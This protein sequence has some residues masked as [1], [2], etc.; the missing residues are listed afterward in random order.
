MASSLDPYQTFLKYVGEDNLED[1]FVTRIKDWRWESS[2]F[3]HTHL[4]L[5]GRPS[6]KAAVA[7]PDLNNAL[8][9]VLGYETEENL[10]RHYDAIHNGELFAGRLQLLLPFDSR[11]EAGSAG[12]AHCFDLV[13]RAA[14]PQG[15]RRRAMVSNQTAGS[16][17][18]HRPAPS[19]TWT[20]SE[21]KI[22]FGT[23]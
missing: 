19:G 18:L 12:Q 1:R 17:P 23:T 21:R 8:I 14:R 20:V 2:S 11:S 3:F 4:A 13:A 22:S 9:T 5:N 10:I 16:R 6:F 15:G 7:N